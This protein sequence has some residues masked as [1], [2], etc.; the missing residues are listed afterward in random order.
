MIENTVNEDKATFLQ[1][2][3]AVKTRA[4][5]LAQVRNEFEAA[6][7]AL[8]TAQTT[9]AEKY[10]NGIGVEWSHSEA[11]KLYMDAAKQGVAE[12]QFKVGMLWYSHP[13]GA[14]DKIEA[15]RWYKKAARQG[16]AQAQF[17]VAHSYGCGRGVENGDVEKDAV[18]SLKW[19]KKAAKQGYPEAQHE[20]G[21]L[22]RR[23][24]LSKEGL[25]AH[26]EATRWFKKAAKQ[27][28]FAS[29]RALDN[30]EDWL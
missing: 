21:M 7:L 1:A 8:A 19:Y 26:E 17:Y 9:L 24:Y 10:Y 25:V 22:Y 20:L 28:Y 6:K 4:R 2:V 18:K 15:M 16:H 13:Y 14:N 27:A 11:F 12:A 29:Q 3:A 23:R 5:E 30:P